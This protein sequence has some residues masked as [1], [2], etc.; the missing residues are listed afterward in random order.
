MWGGL[1]IWGPAVTWA[2]PGQVPKSNDNTCS[3]QEIFCVREKRQEHSPPTGAPSPNVW[4]W[5][6][7]VTSL[8][9]HLENV[10]NDPGEKNP[11]HC[12]F[13]H[14][15]AAVWFS[16]F[17]LPMKIEWD[18]NKFNWPYRQYIPLRNSGGWGGKRT[19]FDLAKPQIF[20][21]HWLEQ[22]W[23]VKTNLTE[24]M[25]RTAGYERRQVKHRTV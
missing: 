6:T 23:W 5:A 11:L 4:L 22:S 17:S 1:D 15:V 14:K 2:P 10:T 8:A 21:L 20:R 25:A 19:D 16:F 18:W 12:L 3:S 9:E 13:L 7:Q 24:P